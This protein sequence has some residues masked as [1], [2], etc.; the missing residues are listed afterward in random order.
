MAGDGADAGQVYAGFGQAD[1]GGVAQVHE[2]QLG[3]GDGEGVRVGRGAARG[4][5]VH[6]KAGQLGDAQF[7]VA[8]GE[9][10]ADA[11]EDV[12]EVVG[13][14]GQAGFVADDDVAGRGFSASARSRTAS[15]LARSMPGQVEGFGSPTPDAAQFTAAA[16]AEMAWKI[17]AHRL[18]EAPTISSNAAR[19]EQRPCDAASA[20][21]LCFASRIVCMVDALRVWRHNVRLV[22]SF[23]TC[24]L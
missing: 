11:G 13:L 2:C 10:I 4:E 15:S 22:V 12:A 23:P 6:L 14:E 16:I 20:P 17:R 24:L 8:G 1:H 5:V 9:F 19:R 21:M 18:A 7:G 3:G